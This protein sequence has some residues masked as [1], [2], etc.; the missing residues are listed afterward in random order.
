VV[1]AAG[2]KSVARAEL[3]SEG[4]WRHAAPGFASIRAAFA[5]PVVGRRDDATLVS[6]YFRWEIDDMLVRPADATVSLADGAVDGLAAGPRRGARDATFA[7]RRMLWR[8]T[9]P[10]PARL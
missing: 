2:G 9:W 7:V 10:M 5:L 6:S 8:V 1:T 4:E 3:R